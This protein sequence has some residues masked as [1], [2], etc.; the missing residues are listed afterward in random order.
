MAFQT[1]TIQE[2]FDASIAYLESR[3]NQKTPAAE[4]AYNKV[5]ANMLAMQSG[6]QLKY[7]S[8]RAKEVLTISAS[9]EG[10]TV[11]GQGRDIIRKPATSSVIVFEVPATSGTII[12]TSVIYTADDTGVRYRPDVQVV[13][14]VSNIATI[15][16][17]ALTPGVVGNLNNG[18]TLSADRNVPGA[19]NQGTV[20][21]NT[22]LG[23]EQEQVEVYRQRIL[24]DERTEGGGSNSADYRRWGEKTPGVERIFTYTG[25]SSY[26]QTGTGV[27][28]PVATSHFV[29]ADESL[30]T[31]GVADSTLLALTEQ[32]I[33]TDQETG[34]ANECLTG[35]LDSFREVLSIFNDDYFVT[36]TGLSVSGDKEA[37]VKTDIETALRTY[38]RTVQPFISGLDFEDDRNDTVSNPSVA[39][40]VQDVVG[41]AGGSFTGV[42]VSNSGGI[43]T[44]YPLGV[45]ELSKLSDVGGVSYA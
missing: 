35:D 32:Y 30:G 11:I 43:I 33:K 10:L 44:D 29:K 39:A 19:E 25:Q 41:A 13:A 6:Q 12:E 4:K 24:D 28:N 40:V 16:A 21:D 37:Q 22:T 1:Q 17:T 31:D 23:T 9:I 5:L 34:K 38:F 18:Q 2:V 7:A 14:S 45:G 8:D 27:I 3:I 15:T 26:L 20:T 42:S 36:I